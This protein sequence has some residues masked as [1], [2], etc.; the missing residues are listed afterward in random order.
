MAHDHPVHVLINKKKYELQN[1]VQ[2]GASLKQVAGI[3]PTDVLFL[4]ASGDDEVI[5]NDAAVTLKNGDHLHSQ[6]PADYGLGEEV[7]RE[8]GLEPGRAT[9]H[10]SG[11]F[12]STGAERRRPRLTSLLKMCRPR[13]RVDLTTFFS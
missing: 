1:P 3:P 8:A 6:P 12:S 7:L 4:Q 2:T 13:Q 9:V 5:A 10:A 11:Q